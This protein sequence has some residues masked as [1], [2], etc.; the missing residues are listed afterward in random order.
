MSERQHSSTA[1][2]SV[3]WLYLL[4]LA[5]TITEVL[6]DGRFPTTPRG[7]ISD[8]L[9]TAL[10]L[11]LVHLACPEYDR[12][13]QAAQR[14][15]MTG[16]FNSGRFDLDLEA[17]VRRAQRSDSSLALA[18]VDLDGFKS[19]N[20]SLGHTEG[21]VLL[22]QVAA[23]LQDSVRGDL[24]RCYRIGGDEFAVVLPG[25]SRRDATAVLQRILEQASREGPALLEKGSGLSAGVATLLPGDGSS[26]IFRRADAHLYRAKA[27]GR[28]RVL[29]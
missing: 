6:E 3:R 1:G 12:I 9:L 11:L 14:D 28:N 7:L 18:L 21:N 5:P 20:D 8:V 17:E 16:L 19:V 26:D 27:G 24:D 10:I 29:A 2:R 22:R 4:A 23:I 15:P 25:L 13:A